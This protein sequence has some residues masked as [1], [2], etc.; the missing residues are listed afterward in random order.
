M[1]QILDREIAGPTS[2]NQNQIIK[3]SDITQLPP[4]LAFQILKNL[5]AT[6]LCLAACVWQTLANDEILWLGLCK[7]NWAYAS[8]YSRARGE[9]ISFRKIFLQLDEGTL[10]FNA[11]QGLQYFIENRLLD[12]SCEELTKFIHNTRKLRAGEKRR[13]LQTRRDI[14]ERLIELQSYENQFLPNALRQFFAKLDAP[15]DRN[16]Y[17]SF[18]IENFSKRFHECNKDLGLS[19]ETIYVLCFS[20]ILLSIDLTS[21]HVKNKMSKREFIRNTR[22]AIINGALND[23]L[24]GHLYDNVYLI[25]HVARSTASAH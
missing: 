8:I 11:G 9:G 3:F 6:D 22:R 20:L 4:E 25:G 5:N 24:A 1:G 2:N 7:S 17:L 10:R 16:E 14:L 13:L 23:E 18:L 21:P 12:D 15:E 19:T